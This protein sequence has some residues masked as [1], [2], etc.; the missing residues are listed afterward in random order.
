MVNVATGQQIATAVH[1]Y[2]N[3]VIDEKLPESGVRL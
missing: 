2:A 1:S 3:R